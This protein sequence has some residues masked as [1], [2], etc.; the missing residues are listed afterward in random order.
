MDAKEMN[1]IREKIMNEEPTTREERI[2]YFT[3]LVGKGDAEYLADGCKIYDIDGNEVKG[4]K[5]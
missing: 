3:S 5:I 1:V 4:I 2:V